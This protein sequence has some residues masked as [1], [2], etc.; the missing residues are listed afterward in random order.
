MS[1]IDSRL[2]LRTVAGAWTELKTSARAREN[3]TVMSPCTDAS[4]TCTN[5][6]N[7]KPVEHLATLQ[8]NHGVEEVNGCLQ[9]ESVCVLTSNRS[10][11]PFTVISSI[12]CFTKAPSRA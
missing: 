6:R 7:V 8:L 12:Y 5:K 11:K 4:E 9:N 2:Y 3:L 1:G 10:V